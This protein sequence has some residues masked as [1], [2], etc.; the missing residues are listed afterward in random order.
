MCSSRAAVWTMALSLLWP[1]TA[2]AQTVGTCRILF[3]NLSRETIT[4]DEVKTLLSDNT[5]KEWGGPWELNPGD[6]VL[7]RSDGKT[8]VEGRQVIY[9]VKTMDG[10][11]STDWKSQV[12]QP[13]KLDR[14]VILQYWTDDDLAKLRKEDKGRELSKGEATYR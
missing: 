9:T 10:I 13:L 4:I 1:A 2:A 12:K 6:R 5:K 14:D 7:L 3:E 8:Y 11:K